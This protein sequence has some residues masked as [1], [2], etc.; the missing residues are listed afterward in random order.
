[1]HDISARL[2]EAANKIQDSLIEMTNLSQAIKAFGDNEAALDKLR[3]I[4]QKA[5]EA[6]E[7]QIHASVCGN[8]ASLLNITQGINAIDEIEDMFKIEEQFF[9]K[10]SEYREL[11]ISLINQTVFYIKV[12]INT[13]KLKFTEAASIA[14]EHR[15]REFDNPLRQLLLQ[16][17]PD[18]PVFDTHIS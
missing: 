17:L 5:Y 12:D 10:H 4:R 3:Q 7:E 6:K 15:L 13:A 9:R 2:Y 8:I 11:V 14:Q 1:M 16:L 18:D